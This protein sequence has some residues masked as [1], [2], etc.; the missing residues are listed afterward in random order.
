MNIVLVFEF[1]FCFGW[2]GLLKLWIV[3]HPHSAVILDMVT[4]A[5]K[6]EVVCRSI[7]LSERMCVV[8]SVCIIIHLACKFHS[9]GLWVFLV[10]FCLVK[11]TAFLLAGFYLLASMPIVGNCGLWHSEY[12]C[13][14]GQ[15]WQ[16]LC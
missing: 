12:I 5:S 4:L 2:E 8:L 7:N 1:K 16:T 9:C 14:D 6:S 3:V 13:C 10:C 11:Q 15:G